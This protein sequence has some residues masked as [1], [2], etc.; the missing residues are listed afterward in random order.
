MLSLFL[1][2][3]QH[4]IMFAFVYGNALFEK[5]PSQSKKGWIILHLDSVACLQK[6]VMRYT[7]SP[8]EQNAGLSHVTSAASWQHGGHKHCRKDRSRERSQGHWQ[9]RVKI[10]AT[11]ACTTAR[12]KVVIFYTQSK[13]KYIWKVRKRYFSVFFDCKRGK[14]SRKMIATMKQSARFERKNAG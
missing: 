11:N 2:A 14:T 12:A 3:E 13:H 4:E 5:D 6:V 10:F 8:P 1:G 7:A 9:C